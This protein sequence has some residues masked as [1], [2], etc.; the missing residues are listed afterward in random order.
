VITS[1]SDV[2]TDKTADA[3]KQAFPLA[4]AVA[5]VCSGHNLQDTVLA[6]AAVLGDVISKTPPQHRDKVRAVFMRQLDMS[7]TVL[8]I[9]RCTNSH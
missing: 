3:I 2:M 4:T 9:T 1:W 5:D 6:L 8:P 7:G